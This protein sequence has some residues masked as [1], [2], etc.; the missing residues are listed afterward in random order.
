MVASGN[1]MADRWKTVHHHIGR[2]IPKDFGS[3]LAIVGRMVIHL[4]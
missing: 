3:T 2:K 1:K 4:W